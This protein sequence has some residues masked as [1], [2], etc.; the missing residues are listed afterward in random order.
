MF[1]YFLGRSVYKAGRR[2]TETEGAKDIPEDKN[3]KVDVPVEQVK[4]KLTPFC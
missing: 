3:V 4:Y 2:R 1:C